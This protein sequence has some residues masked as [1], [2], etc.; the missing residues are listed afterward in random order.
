M[1]TRWIVL[2]V[3]A[4]ASAAAQADVQVNFIHPEKFS[5]IKDNNGF[6]DM[7]VLKDIKAHLVGQFEKRLPGRDVRVDVSDVDLAGEVEPFMRRSGQWVRVMRSVTP[8]S[9]ELSYEVREGDKVVQQGKTRLRDLNYQDEFNAYYSGDPLRYE[10]RMIDRWM[11][12]EFNPAVA[13]APGH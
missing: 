6:R 1:K 5:D 3:M 4:L 13:K 12:R 11:D 10:K 2:A 9:I 7:E 8:P